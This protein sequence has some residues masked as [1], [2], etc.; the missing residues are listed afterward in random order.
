MLGACCAWAGMPKP[1]DSNIVEARI[2]KRM[3]VIGRSSR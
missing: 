2:E 1:T 3:V